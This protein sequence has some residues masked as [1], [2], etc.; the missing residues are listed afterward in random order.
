M[1][2]G[3][4]SIKH[5]RRNVIIKSCS[6]IIASCFFLSSEKV[7]IATDI[8]DIEA[9]PPYAKLETYIRTKYDMYSVFKWEEYTKLLDKLLDEKFM[10]LS[11]ND[12]RSTYDKS[13]V[14]VGLRHDVDFN[15]FK[16][17]E[18][19]KIE[20]SYGF[21]ATYY[22]LATAEYFGKISGKELSRS[23]GIENLIKEIHNTGAEIGIHNDLLAIQVLSEIDPLEFNKE[24]LKFYESHDIPIHGTASHGSPFAKNTVPNFQVFSNFA[25][26][27]SAM[28]LGKKFALGLHSLE[29]FGFRYE[30]YFIDYGIY[31]SESGGKWNDPEGLN[32]ILKKLDA[33][34]PG[35]RIQI[36]VHA[37]W[38]G[39]V[40]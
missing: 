35:D 19:A 39:I 11:I 38:W 15:P 22:M 32:G 31:F 28:Y 1:K 21:S 25:K 8:A 17:L 12:M 13:K 16:A 2:K 34:K 7:T 4:C 36:L 10:V 6:L 27:D 40:N 30:A 14:I 3:N 24:E 26:N 5:F 20:K 9:E 37:D 23:P 33:C 29:Q 18:M